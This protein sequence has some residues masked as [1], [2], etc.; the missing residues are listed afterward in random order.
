MLRNR[1]A[2]LVLTGCLGA[3]TLAGCGSGPDSSATSGARASGPAPMAAPG[4]KAASGVESLPKGA[5]AAGGAVSDGT[6]GTDGT[7]KTAANQGR[8]PVT[9]RSLVITAARTI[10]VKGV[11]DAEVKVRAIA[12]LHGGDVS[13]E[14]SSL[15]QSR[16]GDG[17]ER[18]NLVLRVPN[19]TVDAVEAELDA[20]GSR[21]TA[22]RSTVDVTEDVVDV[23]SR[24]SNARRSV[25]R[26]QVLLDKATSISDIVRIEGEL[27]SRE[28]DLDSL[29]ARQRALAGTTAMATVNVTL[30]E[31]APT[32]AVAPARR[33]GFVGGLSS[34]WEAFASTIATIL[35]VIGALLPFAVAAGILGVLAVFIKRGIRAS[36]VSQA[37]RA[38]RPAVS[39]DVV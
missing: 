21:L 2:A 31:Q 35:L 38:A 29:T 33:Q 12:R 32:A 3:V 18:S 28:A 1:T 17:G 5:P 19:S 4:A 39:S 14:D 37:A 34:G 24:V 13:G 10:Q 11:A 27:A 16:N 30:V 9:T 36:R 6:D 22:S 7:A 25:A 15:G 23:D 26:V 20:L 8:L